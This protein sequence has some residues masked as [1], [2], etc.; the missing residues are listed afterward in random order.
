[1][2]GAGGKQ[3]APL[4]SQP[5]VGRSQ[6]RRVRDENIRA[7]SVGTQDMSTTHVDIRCMGMSIIPH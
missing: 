5:F 1:M 7:K 3:S 6:G 2:E 4:E